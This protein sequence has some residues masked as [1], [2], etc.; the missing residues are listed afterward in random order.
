MRTQL[1]E[2]SKNNQII[3]SYSLQLARKLDQKTFKTATQIRKQD[4]I[5]LMNPSVSKLL[6]IHNQQLLTIVKIFPLIQ[7]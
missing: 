3:V 2:T 5:F 1:V 4:E 6:R 7:R